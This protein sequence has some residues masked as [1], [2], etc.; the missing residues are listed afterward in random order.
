MA[1]VEDRIAKGKAKMVELFGPRAAE[2]GGP[3]FDMSPEFSNLVQEVV[4][5]A[6]WS[7]PTLDTRLRSFI[8]MS[9]LIALDRQP[10]LRIHFRGAL[11]LGIP[12]E[13]II[14]LISHLAFYGG[15]PVAVNSLR[16]AKE[17][18][19]KWDAAKGKAGK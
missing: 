10:E 14:A 2:P 9:A 15:M 5:G 16:T 8:T 3:L 12:R 17:V 19:E 11:N 4:F 18:F 1:T 6:V 7:D 13:Q